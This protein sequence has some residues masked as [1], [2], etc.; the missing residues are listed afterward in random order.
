MNSEITTTLTPFV[1]K[2]NT[3]RNIVSSEGTTFFEKP[4]DGL[5]IQDLFY[6]FDGDR[7]CV[8]FPTEDHQRR[9]CFVNKEGDRVYAKVEALPND[10]KSIQALRISPEST[11]LKTVPKILLVDDSK[12]VLKDM[13]RKLKQI[14]STKSCPDQT[15]DTA[16]HGLDA[17]EKVDQCGYDIIFMDLHMSVPGKSTIDGFETSA[18][19]REI[20]KK[21]LRQPAAIILFTSD[22][23]V[24]DLPPSI[25][26]ALIKG[27]GALQP[28]ITGYL[29]RHW[30]S[31]VQV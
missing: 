7:R 3:D 29:E 24:I 13:S 21:S 1:L 16:E 18:R 19:I 28:V 9:W 2:V 22:E 10:N 20:E 17:L 6:T 26:D 23:S 15:V 14:F 12:I 4:L 5:N 25:D 31:E 27:R 8:S 30:P 11:P